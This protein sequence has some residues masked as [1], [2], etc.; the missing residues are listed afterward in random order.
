MIL[1]IKL[2]YVEGVFNVMKKGIQNQ[3]QRTQKKKKKKERKKERQKQTPPK[4]PA[5]FFFYLPWYSMILHNKTTRPA[6]SWNLST[7]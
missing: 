3:Y 4:K 2:L 6:A 5:V 1:C 7:K